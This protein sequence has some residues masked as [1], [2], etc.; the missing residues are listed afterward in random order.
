MHSIDFRQQ[1]IEHSTATPSSRQEQRKDIADEIA[2]FLASG[3]NIDEVPIG[4]SGQIQKPI[5]QDK[6]IST[7]KAEKILGISRST[8]YKRQ[9]D[10]IT[11]FRSKSGYYKKQRAT[12]WLLEDI[13]A[14]ADA[15]N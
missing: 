15:A 6:W 12:L 7:A 8:I 13:V 10:G 9:R 4:T 3:G 2:T 14:A 5:K 1:N 11:A